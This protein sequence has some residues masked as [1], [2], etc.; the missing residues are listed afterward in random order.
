MEFGGFEF[1]YEGFFEF[2]CMLVDIE[3]GFNCVVDGVVKV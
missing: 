1:I 2:E 3:L